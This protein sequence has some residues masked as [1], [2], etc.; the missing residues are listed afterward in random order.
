MVCTYIVLSALRITNCPP[1]RVLKITINGRQTYMIS[2]SRQGLH[3]YSFKLCSIL[4][5]FPAEAP[6]PVLRERAELFY[7]AKNLTVWTIKN[8][9]KYRKEENHTVGLDDPKDLASSYTFYLSNPVRV[10]KNHTDLG[11]DHCCEVCCRIGS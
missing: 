5:L 11:R 3:A 8:L 7:N 1:Q 10:M 2:N 6:R 9:Q 4:H